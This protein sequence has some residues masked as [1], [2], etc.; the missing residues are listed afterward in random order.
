MGRPVAPA[1][2]G[3]AAP[4]V[5][6]RPRSPKDLISNPPIEQLV[7]TTTETTTI[8]VRAEVKE[9][10]AQAKG[11]K[12]WD[13]FLDEVAEEYLDHAIALA[14]ERLAALKAHK[15]K[16]RSL[17][18]LDREIQNLPKETRQHGARRQ[19]GLDSPDSPGSVR[20][21]S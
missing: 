16:A 13:E 15:A 17:L 6:V 10:L 3:G 4:D 20:R 8:T 12:S 7:A 14:E 21:A 19:R 2:F 11:N 1:P 18:D 5:H 9:R